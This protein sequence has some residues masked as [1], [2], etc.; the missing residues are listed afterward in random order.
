[1]FLPL[2]LHRQRPLFLQHTS[3]EVVLIDLLST[4]LN[5][6]IATYTEIYTYVIL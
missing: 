5:I 1:M 2:P 4:T 6:R 3:C